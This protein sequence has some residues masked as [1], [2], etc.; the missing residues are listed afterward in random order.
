MV[1]FLPMD[2]LTVRCWILES[3]A[4]EWSAPSRGQ[5]SLYLALVKGICEY[6]YLHEYAVTCHCVL[7]IL[8][9]FS[10]LRFP[11]HTSNSSSYSNVPTPSCAMTL[12]SPEGKTALCCWLKPLACW[13]SGLHRSPDHRPQ[14]AS[15]FLWRHLL[16]L[17]PLILWVTV[18]SKSVCDLHCPSL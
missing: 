3:G 13:L 16:L 1:S 6:A 14:T 12:P 17:H 2:L 8:H 11:A 4:L 18:F 15:C 10:F 5:C 7:V 9:L